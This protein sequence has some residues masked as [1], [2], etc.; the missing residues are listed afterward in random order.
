MLFEETFKARVSLRVDGVAYHLKED[1]DTD[2]CFR[3]LSRKL[4][5]RGR[6]KDHS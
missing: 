5:V 1:N 6:S 2:A 3:I 4:P